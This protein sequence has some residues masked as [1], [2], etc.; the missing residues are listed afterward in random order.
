MTDKVDGTTQP[1]ETLVGNLDFITL[2]LDNVNFSAQVGPATDA[3]FSVNGNPGLNFDPSDQTRA[4]GEPL[5]HSQKL[6]DMVIEL[7]SQRAQPVVL[8]I[9]TVKIMNLVIEHTGV[10]TEAK[11][12]AD[13]EDAVQ[14][15]ADIAG[16]LHFELVTVTVNIAATIA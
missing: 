4:L 9:S 16:G 8:Q 1:A 5:D 13:I 3:E 12:K 2:T 6:T 11:L 15:F 7:I 10:W 14:R